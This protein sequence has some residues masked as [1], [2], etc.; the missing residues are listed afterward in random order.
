MDASEVTK[1]LFN[2][3][4]KNLFSAFKL[5]L[6]NADGSIEVSGDFVKEVTV[7]EVSGEAVAGHVPSEDF[8]GDASAVDFGDFGEFAS[9]G[10]S[11]VDIKGANRGD[12]F[13]DDDAVH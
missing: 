13:D 11:V 7:V 3:S 1:V 4:K 10:F 6:H 5:L 9:A 8:M 2:H 12:L